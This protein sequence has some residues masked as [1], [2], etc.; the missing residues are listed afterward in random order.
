MSLLLMLVSIGAQPLQP[1]PY[2]DPAGRQPSS[3]ADYVATQTDEPFQA[4]VVCRSMTDGRYDKLVLVL[5]NSTLY[6][7][8]TPQFATWFSDIG[9]P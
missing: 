1:I 7:D 9:D 3:Y 8:L 5:V 4:R 2:F 6:S